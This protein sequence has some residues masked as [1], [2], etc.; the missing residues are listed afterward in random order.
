MVREGY[1]R[2][3]GTTHSGKGAWEGGNHPCLQ[4]GT[5]SEQRGVRHFF[6]GLMAPGIKGIYTQTRLRKRQPHPAYEDRGVRHWA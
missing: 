5:V 1:L 3:T 6:R 4:K 2:D